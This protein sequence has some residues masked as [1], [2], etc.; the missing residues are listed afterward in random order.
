MSLRA[1]YEIGIGFPTGN[2]PCKDGYFSIEGG[3]AYG[4]WPRLV[5]MLNMPE[6]LEDP[7]FCTAEA[8]SDPENYEAFLQIFLPWC[9]ERTKQEITMLGQAKRVFVTPV[10]SPKDLLDD[11]HLKARGFFVDIDHPMTGKIKYPGAPFR[12]AIPFQVRRP[13]PILGQHN[14]EVYGQLGYSKEDL[15]KLRELGVI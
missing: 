1:P 13:A 15:V 6:L 4:F 9:M 12:T 2:Y 7:R 11:M 3:A 5:T 10:N 8:Q 14:E